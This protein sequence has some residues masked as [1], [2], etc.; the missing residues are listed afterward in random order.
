MLLTPQEKQRKK[1]ANTQARTTGIRLGEVLG[2]Q[3]EEG[4]VVYNEESTILNIRELRK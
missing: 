1:A 3:S 4:K 2:H